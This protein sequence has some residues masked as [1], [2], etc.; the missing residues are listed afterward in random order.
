MITFKEIEMVG[1]KSFADLTKISFDGGITAIVGPNGCGKSNVSD[2]IRWVLGEQSSKAFRGKSM[3]DVIF[4]GTEKRK[5]L[6]YCE[7]SLVFDNTNKWFNIEYDEVVLTRKLYRSGESDYMINRKP[8]RLKDIRDILY[9]S[10]IGKDGYSIIG[11]GRVEEIIQ[12]KPEERRA[13]FEEA[14]GIAKY[15]AR[16]VET[17]N[18]LERVRDNLSRAGDIMTEVERRL[19][20]LKRQS[21]DAKKYL[22]YR[23]ILKNLEINAY[24]YQ[25][26]HAAQTKQEINEKLT[27][28]RDNLNVLTQ[29]MEAEQAKYD[30]SM[31]EISAL[32]KKAN[33]LHEQVLQH[34]IALEKKQSDSRLLNEQARYLKEQISRLE[35]QLNTYNLDLN[36]RNTFVNSAIH[37]RN[38]EQKNLENLR[39]ENEKITEQYMQLVDEMAKTE[40][41][42]EENQR[43][44]IDNLS[45][46][47]DIKANLSAYIAKRDT[48]LENI[49]QDK[50]KLDNA[51]LEKTKIEKEYAELK[52]TVE[53]LTKTKAKKQEN[54][55]NLNQKLTNLSADL[56]EINSTI[57]AL[58]TSIS[59]DT[60]RKNILTNL[61]AD[62]E[63]YQFAV[64]RLLQ[65][66]KN[67][68]KL[69]SA[70]K[71]VVGNIINVDEKYQTAIEIALGGSIQ[72]I[73]T[74]DENDAKVL[75]DY[76]KNSRLGRA[77]FL[78][79]SAVKPRSINAADKK[80]LS[81]KGCLGVASELVKTDAIYRPVIDSL[82]GATVVCDN[83][84]N[85]VS[86]AKQSGY[87]FRIV[88]LEGDVLSPQGSMSGGSKKSNDSSLLSKETEI[89]NLAKNIE[90][91]SKELDIITKKQYAITTEIDN[92]KS[93]YKTENESLQSVNSE[94]YTFNTKLEGLKSNLESSEEDIFSLSSQ[95]KVAENIV[96]ELNAQINSIDKLEQDYNSAQAKVGQFNDTQKSQ[97]E[98]LKHKREQHAEIMT[99]SKVKI[100]STEE[101]IKSLNETIQTQTNEIDILKSNIE[102][103]EN[104]LN[105]QQKVLNEALNLNK[106]KGSD[107]E[108]SNLQQNL[109]KL[110]LKISQFD[111]FKQSLLKELKDLDDKKTVISNDISKLNNKIYQE[112][113]KLQKVDID[114]ENMQERIYEEYEMTYNDC[115]PFKDQGEDYDIKENLI[116][117]S[118]IKNQIT[119]LGYVNINA[120]EE[121]KT[122]GARYEEMNTQIEDLKKAEEDA[123]KII[124]ELS[125]EMLEKFNVEF[126][127]IQENFTKVF[128]ELFGGGNARLELLPSED[129]LTAGVEIIA[130]PPGK[131][132]QNITLMS[133]GEKTMTAIAILFAILKLKPMPFCFLDEIEAALD[134][135]NIDRYANYLKRFSNETQFIVITHR[136]P[137]MEVVDAL[138]G[139]TMEEKGVSKIVS[140]KLADAVKTINAE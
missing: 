118:R 67:N 83:L 91:K 108:V 82:L 79:I 140:V 20:P 32:D 136:K 139:V 63:G 50:L 97:Y 99:T 116:K 5:K 138:Y 124:K 12:S 34:T 114:I 95:L 55:D 105:S 115:L 42:K 131:V 92:V 10:G 23:D 29:T 112:E 16:K 98:E 64:K 128:K 113:S 109:D 96:S 129:P 54:I 102:R 8:C 80:Y 121:Y 31:N 101:K 57:Y 61:Q 75:I 38:E 28:Y 18:R 70:I 26:D 41:E 15:K 132:L 11:Q 39:K 58:K 77:T 81:A 78:P 120:I 126:V 14:A 49:R 52:S 46:L 107:E 51:D 125:A 30:K 60:N 73:V 72:N 36:Q 69:G 4:A 17:E 1:F 104:E 93:Q 137:T 86:V 117:I 2:A 13:I 111:E 127:K 122:E 90:E 94:F 27:G 85:A 76:L 24:I 53:N 74:K 44:I 71:G 19:G 62:F 68:A 56:E 35:T 22:E 21:E 133:G 88:T 100:A 65:E 40:G 43:N 33:E 6:S 110:N 7:V 9:D 87:A 84:D 37:M 89:K 47:T 3:Q 106:S 134:D 123:V 130:Q 103:V 59:N 48:L 119:A 25:F 66:G 45:K 135:A